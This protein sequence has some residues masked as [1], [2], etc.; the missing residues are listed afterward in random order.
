MNPTAQKIAPVKSKNLLP[1]DDSRYL[2]NRELSWLEFNRRV[3][4]EALDE[5][6][7]PLERHQI[8]PQSALALA[9]KIEDS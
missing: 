9:S 1:V 7:P 8:L 3:L 4:D 5:T 6:T 2:L